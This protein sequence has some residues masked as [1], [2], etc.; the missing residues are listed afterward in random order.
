MQ[1]SRNMENRQLC[2]YEISA[3]IDD[4]QPEQDSF[5]EIKLTSMTNTVADLVIATELTDDFVDV[6]ALEQGDVLFARHPQ[7]LILSVQSFKNEGL[8]FFEVSHKASTN[9]KL[10]NNRQRCT[11]RQNT[12][13]PEK[14]DSQIGSTV[15]GKDG[16]GWVNAGGE[17]KYQ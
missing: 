1:P 9:L 8:F 7:K 3:G 17:I 6:C 2:N 11:R 12:L 15:G 13:S 16:F 4:E 5:L 14:E 10:T